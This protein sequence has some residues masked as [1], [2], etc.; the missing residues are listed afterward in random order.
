MATGAR[1]SYGGDRLEAEVAPL[2]V[3]TAVR[4][5]CCVFLISSHVSAVSAFAPVPPGVPADAGA[6][7]PLHSP[8]DQCEVSG[9]R[10][11]PPPEVGVRVKRPGAEGL[12]MLG[13]RAY[14]DHSESYRAEQVG[15]EYTL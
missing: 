3:T 10:F 12:P 13:D 4:R 9:R 7:F 15:A 6:G 8:W 5:G 2:P 14:P 11:Y 1:R